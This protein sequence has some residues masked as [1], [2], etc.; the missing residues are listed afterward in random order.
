MYPVCYHPAWCSVSEISLARPDTDRPVLSLLAADDHEEPTPQCAQRL[1][2]L[3]DQGA[4]VQWHILPGTTHTWDNQ[5][6]SGK[7]S[8]MPWMPSAGQ[9]RYDARATDESRDRLF[10]FLKGV[11]A[12]VAGQ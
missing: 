7:S 1:Q 2:F 12:G 4:P 3:K 5:G 9:Y 10:G 6:A 8:K 11:F